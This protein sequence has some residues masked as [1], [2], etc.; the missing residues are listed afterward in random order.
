MGAWKLNTY[1]HVVE[2][3]GEGRSATFGPADDLPDWAVEA[4]TNPDVWDGPAPEA[5][6]VKSESQADPKPNE[7]SAAGS[8]PPKG[9]AGSGAQAWREY[10]ASKGVV[11]ADDATRE[12]IIAAL[13]EAGVPT[14]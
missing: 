10:A 1:V 5:P 12:D 11:V 14:E 4:I 3:G 8:P 13:T 7:N 2:P 9:G 6:P